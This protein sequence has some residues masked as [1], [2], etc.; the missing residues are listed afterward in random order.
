M[1]GNKY[2]AI[3]V[4]VILVLMLAYNI[5]FFTA[6]NRRHEPTGG[7]K[8]AI[9]QQPEPV[10]VNPPRHITEPED[11]SKWKRDP[12]SLQPLLPQKTVSKIKKK[13]DI[14]EGI[15]LMGIIKRNGKSLALIDGKIYG[16][17]D[18]IGDAVIKA[19]KKEGIV[20]LSD[21]QSKEIS[22]EDY[23]LLK[24]KKK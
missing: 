15:H 21:G 23:K 11:R 17:N 16:V 22:F 2:V 18:T 24:E 1:L 5:E 7:G 12:F 9:V 3:A 10:V 6:K 20:I 4:G 14:T 19:I 13:P 8:I